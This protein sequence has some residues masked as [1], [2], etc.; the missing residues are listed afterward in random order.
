MNDGPALERATEWLPTLGGLFCALL[1]PVA[2]YFL[3]L[4]LAPLLRPVLDGI[5]DAAFF[6]DVRIVK[7]SPFRYWRECE[8]LESDVCRW[9][10]DGGL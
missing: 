4:L 1:L 9:E 10:D 2:A 6:R 7:P 8:E 5:R 3:L